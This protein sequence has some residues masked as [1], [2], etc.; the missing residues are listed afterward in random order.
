MNET[1]KILEH[2]RSSK[3]KERR[4]A[5][6]KIGKLKVAELSSDLLDAFIK[7]QQDKR[8]WETQKEMIIALGKL[9]C[10]EAKDHLDL[11]I[12]KN[13]ENDMITTAA[14]EAFVRISRSSLEDVQPIIDLVSVG[15]YAVITGAFAPLAKDQM[16]PSEDQIK[17]LLG[18]VKDMHKR[19][20][21]AGKEFGLFD[22][23][24]YLAIA[25]ANWDRALTHDFLN[26]CIS[27]CSYTDRFGDKMEDKELLEVCNNSLEGKTSK[28]FLG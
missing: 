20:D 3:S 26:Y 8:T 14:A 6:K 13:L 15:N 22:P 5:A 16:I 27:N 7:E 24:L 11:I 2:L 28:R 12:E 19:S 21:Y 17:R 9:D 18:K 25:C 1:K 10:K 4:A 23:R